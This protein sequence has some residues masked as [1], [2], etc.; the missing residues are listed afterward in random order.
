MSLQFFINVTGLKKFVVKG[1][2]I[3]PGGI[4]DNSFSRHVAPRFSKNDLTQTWMNDRR[5]ATQPQMF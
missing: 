3:I 5:S 2:S 1:R 4:R